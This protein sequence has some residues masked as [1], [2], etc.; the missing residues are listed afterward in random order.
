MQ[1]HI[2][3]LYKNF[4]IF[5]ELQ[6]LISIVVTPFLIGWGLALSTI[7]ILGNLI[8]SQ[9]LTSFICVSC[10]IFTTDMFGISNI[11]LQKTLNLLTSIWCFLLSCA[12]S[13]WLI[14]FPYTFL[15]GACILA[16]ISCGIYHY[17]IPSQK[18]RLSILLSL[19]LV[20]PTIHFATRQTT[21]H[22]VIEVG[23]KKFYIILYKNQVYGIDLQA[24]GAKKGYESW[25]EYTL[26]PELIKSTGLYKIDCLITSCHTQRSKKAFEFLSKQLPIHKIIQ[27]ASN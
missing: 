20:L 3:R 24:L 14:A 21:K 4:L 7:S 6:L 16:I 8:F 1:R 5:L 25:I 18:I 23:N 15:P 26:I 12:S 17:Q 2:H 27:I 19:S 11:L 9:F 13:Y 10:A 22:H